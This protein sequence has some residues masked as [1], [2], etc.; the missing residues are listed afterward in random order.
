M[1]DLLPGGWNLVFR[2]GASKDY[3][4]KWDLNQF[5]YCDHWTIIVIFGLS[6]TGFDCTRHRIGFPS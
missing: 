3:Q 6:V 5:L 2:N 1:K 4:L